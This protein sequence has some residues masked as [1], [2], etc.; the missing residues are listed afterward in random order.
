MESRYQDG[1]FHKGTKEEILGVKRYFGLQ[2]RP[3]DSSRA[4]V[5]GLGTLRIVLQFWFL[6]LTQLENSRS[7]DLQIIFKNS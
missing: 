7:E 1:Q 5:H 4:A 6:E 2:K 3:T